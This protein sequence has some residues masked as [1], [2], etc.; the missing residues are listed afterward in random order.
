MW[1]VESGCSCAYNKSTSLFPYHTSEFQHLF[2]VCIRNESQCTVN[3][4]YFV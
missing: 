2:L 3:C 1:P 4:M